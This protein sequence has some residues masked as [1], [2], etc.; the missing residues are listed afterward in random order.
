LQEA[1]WKFLKQ[2]ALG[3]WHPTF[4]AMQQAVSEVLDHLGEYRE[5]LATLMVDEFHVIQK[6]DIPV[7]YRGA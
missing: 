1:R 2:K 5:E 4:E 3:R 6:E 7:Q